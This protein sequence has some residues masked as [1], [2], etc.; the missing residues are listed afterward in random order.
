MLGEVTLLTPAED[1]LPFDVDIELIELA[2]ADDGIELTSCLDCSRETRGSR[3]IASGVAVND[4]D[5]HGFSLQVL[6]SLDA[7]KMPVQTAAPRNMRQLT[8]TSTSQSCDVGY[9][10]GWI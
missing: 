1:P 6:D 8:I 7:P 2:G 3:L 4:Q 10:A 9:F 5:P